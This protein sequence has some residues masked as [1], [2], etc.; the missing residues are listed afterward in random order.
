MLQKIIDKILLRRETRLTLQDVAAPK[1]SSN[2]RRAL[3][4]VLRRADAEQRAVTEKAYEIRAN[5]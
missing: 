1:P 4:E 5:S 3:S 2:V